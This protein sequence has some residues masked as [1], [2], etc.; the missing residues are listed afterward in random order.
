MKFDKIIED[1]GN[2]WQ[3]A[4]PNGIIN[5]NNPYH[6]V[7]LE[8]VLDKFNLTREQKLRMLNGIRGIK[9][10]DVVKNKKTG[11]TYVVKKHNP[12][13][14]N[15]VK[16]DASPEDMEKVEKGEEKEK[17]SSANAA[18]KQSEKDNFIM[19][20]IDLMRKNLSMGR[21]EGVAGE[22]DFKTQ[23]E[24][25]TMK[26][27][28]LRKDK[29]RIE[30]EKYNKENNLEE[31]DEG[32]KDPFLRQPKIYD[33]SEE[34]IDKVM[35]ELEKQ[36]RELSKQAK[37]KGQ[38]TS[39]FGPKY[40]INKIGNKGA[41]NSNAA[42]PERTR[43]V[44][45]HYLETGGISIITGKPVAFSASQLD[46][47]RSLGLGGNDEPDNWHWMEARFNQVKGAR[48]DDEVM[49]MIEGVIKQ[50]PEAF[51]LGKLAI[52]IKNI[53]K[54]G[55]KKLFTEKF[56]NGDHAGLTE[57]NLTNYTQDELE[58]IVKGLNAANNWGEGAESVKRYAS[59]KDTNPD[60]PTFGQALSRLFSDGTMR[61]IAKKP[62]IKIY[63]KL[64]SGE[65]LNDK[66]KEQ[67]KKDRASWGVVWNP[68]TDTGS[69]A[70]FE[71]IV[72]MEDGTEID[73]TTLVNWKNPKTGKTEKMPIGFV[74]S[75]AQSGET[76]ESGGKKLPVN[77]MRKN[78]IE[79]F[80]RSDP[81]GALLTKAESD[82]VDKDI[83]KL[84]DDL[85]AKKL[86]LKKM[87]KS[88]K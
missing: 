4:I 71:Y 24:A 77:K 56:S 44:L 60:S 86:D 64:A 35:D 45:R 6:V 47:A 39:K 51:K 9:E 83:Q 13:T 17:S 30:A 14:Q 15:L 69:P 75:V 57:E 80:K 74:K 23:E 29:H 38:K 8:S 78:I 48:E 61:V 59:N 70:E 27:F 11:N 2:A 68:D 3:D 21:Q 76:R 25:Q 34:D 37:E 53:Q 82:V 65:K 12:D 20:T 5:K 55:F 43:E 72:K 22:F 49:K 31:G 36:G 33:V 10:D 54:T 40:L 88:L 66:E 41:P 85:K 26:D 62:K 50:K 46:H 79:G 7:I 81:P 52:E 16:K 42:T 28:Y 67:V 18:K 32:Y 84:K 63:Q 1:I 19:N 87:R 58:T 73:S